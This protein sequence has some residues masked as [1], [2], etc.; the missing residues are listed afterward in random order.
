MK[1]PHSKYAVLSEMFSEVKKKKKKTLKVEVVRERE[2]Q[3]EK[4]GG[5]Y[6]EFLL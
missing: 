4:M 5:R 3:R 2:K 6:P 1:I